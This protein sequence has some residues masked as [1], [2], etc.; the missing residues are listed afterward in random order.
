MLVYPAELLV[1]IDDDSK[2]FCGIVN[3]ASLNNLEM[4]VAT[5]FPLAAWNLVE[6]TNPVFNSI[7]SGKDMELIQ[8]APSNLTTEWNADVEGSIH[9]SYIHVAP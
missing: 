6:C 2:G 8:V 7:P 1:A 3:Q 4:V 9:I 5:I